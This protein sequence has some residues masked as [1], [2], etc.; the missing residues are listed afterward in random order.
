MFLVVPVIC[1][2]YQCH[3]SVIPIY[4]CM[5]HRNLKHFAGVSSIAIAI[6]AFAYSFSAS[7][8]Y[9]T[10]GSVVN[11]DILLDYPADRPEVMVGVVAMAVK[12]VF[13]YPILL[14]CGRE[15]FQTAIKDAKMRYV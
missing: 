6:C 13:T 14:F 8:G 11:P 2:G 5:R 15:A 10:F 3:V 9:L 7:C 4:S 12:T 1:F